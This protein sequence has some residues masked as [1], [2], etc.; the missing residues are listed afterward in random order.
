MQCHLRSP[1]YDQIG[2]ADF[3]FNRAHGITH[4]PQQQCTSFASA[5]LYRASSPEKRSTKTLI[6]SF[7]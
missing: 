7:D 5:A 1:D 2:G 4:F 3:A 6:I